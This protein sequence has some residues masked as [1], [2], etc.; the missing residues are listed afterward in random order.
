MSFDENPIENNEPEV[1]KPQEGQFVEV[2]PI[3]AASAAPVTNVPDSTPMYGEPVNSGE[4][5]S[6]ESPSS[7][8]PPKKNNKKIWI[9]VAVVL[10]LLCCCCVVI[11]AITISNSTFFEDMYYEFSLLPQFFSAVAA[12]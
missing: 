9:I 4:A 6:F 10:V 11:A 5:P 8:E 12:I 1:V 3:Q 2:E 7:G